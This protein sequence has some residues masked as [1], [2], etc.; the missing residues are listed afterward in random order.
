MNKKQRAKRRKDEANADDGQ[1]GS[2]KNIPDNE[3]ESS[4]EEEEEAE[5]CGELPPVPDYQISPKLNLLSKTKSE[6]KLNNNRLSSLPKHKPLCKH[7]SL[8][9]NF[10]VHPS[11]LESTS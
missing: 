1:T 6:L 7:V 4:S 8:P 3:N 5:D 11:V 9:S 10:K 2:D